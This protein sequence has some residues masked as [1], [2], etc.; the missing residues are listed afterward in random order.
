MKF[1]FAAL[2]LA[3]AEAINL[4][5]PKIVDKDNIAFSKPQD[6]V[7]YRP[8]VDGD[9][10]LPPSCCNNYNHSGLSP[11]QGPLPLTNPVFGNGDNV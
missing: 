5:E 11:P 3:S 9:K 2:L 10:A 1:I 7:L 6:P 4:R 8:Y